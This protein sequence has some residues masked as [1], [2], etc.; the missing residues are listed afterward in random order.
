MSQPELIHHSG[1][2]WPLDALQDW[3]ESFWDQINAWISAAGSGITGFITS[4]INTVSG[5]INGA[6]ESLKTWISNSIATVQGWISDV[7]GWISSG[8]SAICTFISNSITA[9]GTWISDS[10]GWL[11]AQISAGINNIVTGLSNIGAWL[12]EQVS[13]V[14]GWLTGIIWGWIDGA[15]RWA[16]D[17]FRWL[18][19]EIVGG[20]GWI[21]SSVCDAFSEIL[22]NLMGGI[23]AIFRPLIEALSNFGTAVSNFL[24]G[25][26]LSAGFQ[27]LIDLFAGVSGVWSGFFV[28]HSPIEPGEALKIG[29]RWREDMDLQLQGWAQGTLY[30]EAISAGQ[31]DIALSHAMHI[32]KIRAASDL[33]L[34]LYKEEFEV[35]LLIPF[36][37]ALMRVYTP[38]IPPIPDLIR[39][40]VR[41][42]I[43]PEKFYELLPLMGYSKEKAEWFWEAHWILPSPGSLY[44]AFHRGVISA[45]ELDKY[46]VL[47]DFKPDPRPGITVSDQHIMRSI[48]KTLIPRVDLRYGWEMG[49]LTD[50]E[51]VEWY[52]RLGYEE[53]SP[54]MADIQKGRAMVE[55][56]TKIRDEWIRDFIDGFIQEETLRANLEVIGIGP[57]RINYY[58]T[59]AAKKR[60]RELLKDLI[61]LYEDGFQ[62]DLV[63]EE[64]L[65][66]RLTEIIVVPEVA[67]LRVEKA[68]TKKYRKPA[69]PKAVTETKAE[70]EL[71]KYRVSYALQ[72]Y[73]RYAIEKPEFVTMLVEAGVDPAVAAARA[74]YEELKRPTPKPSPEEIARN[75]ELARVQTLAV[76]A[77]I[78]EFRD[79]IIDRDTLERRLIEA[80]L[81]EALASATTQLE[82]IRRPPPPIM[83]E[84]IERRRVE[85]EVKRLTGLALATQYHRYAIEKEEL[86]SGLILAGF[87]PA[88]AAARADLEEARR[89]VPRP[90]AEELEAEREERRIRKL[91]ESEALTLFRAEAI[92][93]E[94]LA[95]R[96]R[97]LEYSEDLIAAMV[98]FEEIKLAL[99]KGV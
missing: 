23:G 40:V 60:E 66:D 47:H 28:G 86:I 22:H 11:L 52:E 38:L 94:E 56:I 69:A 26:D 81:T 50:D 37:Q 9:I 19:D 78:E 88:E 48:I 53:D 89:P 82:N 14:G 68:Y 3:F 97:A 32:P 25:I 74:D 18:R 43:S 57:M 98:R 49:R 63:T 62:K 44:D 35:S 85:A 33:G 4:S 7:A 96:L 55:E 80:G 59:Y 84:E 46:I 73:R 77:A 5:W 83:P 21:V 67:D 79:Y 90:P 20:F 65:R 75:K 64:E 72:L 16:T 95:E 41:E 36:R 8:V 87:D 29:H 27:V 34:Q 92:S 30:A 1:W 15:L 70:K 71:R 91:A 42:V 6:V 10:A 61:D 93:S 51:L 17:T 39:F 2:P 76:R 24:A 58:V 31:L 45:G 54:L 12:S 99:K 13:N